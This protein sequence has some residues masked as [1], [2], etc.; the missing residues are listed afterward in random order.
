M[1][2]QG[3]ANRDKEPKKELPPKNLEKVITGQVIQK[4]KS[5]GYK[6]KET[7]FGGDAKSAARYVAGDVLLPALR[8][9]LFD[10]VVGGVEKVIYGD[11]RFGRR[12]GRPPT[13]YSARYQYDRS[14]IRTTG[15][16]VEDRPS[17]PDQRPRVWRAPKRE[18]NDIILSS[19]EEADVVVEKLMDILE[20]YD[21]V[22]LSDLY[23]ILGLP[24]DPI[25]NKW[26]WTYL[27]SLRVRQHRDG[28][29][30]EF[31]SLQEI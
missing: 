9:L 2:Y 16:P 28:H 5:L 6:F 23:E 1:D 15:R 26:G 31:P 11:S 18:F 13:N 19:R 25:D 10:S 3:N 24:I 8:N 30:I 21:V 29:I 22:S 20:K 12:A 27:G 17:L 4:P 7:F 14:P